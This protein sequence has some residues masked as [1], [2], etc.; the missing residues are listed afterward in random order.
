MRSTGN[1]IVSL[2][3]I[4]KTRTIQPGFYS[5][6]LSPTEKKIFDQPDIQQIPFHYFV[7][8]LWSIKESA[9]KYLQRINPDLVFS[10]IRF[11]VTHLEFSDAFS[12][13][14]FGETQLEADGFENSQVIKGSVTFGSTTLF[15][16]SV[17]YTELIHSVVSSSENFENI[18]WGIKLIERSD[19]AYQSSEVR[20]FLVDKLNKCLGVDGLFIEKDEWGVPMIVDGREKIEIALS[21]SHHDRFVGYSFDL[22][23]VDLAAI[24]G[25]VSN[26]P[27]CTPNK[28]NPF[29]FGTIATIR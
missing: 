28:P 13:T 18:G 26:N 1:D 22:S 21:L 23:I 15:S 4:N 12:L 24:V 14:N 3:A 20:V 10:P 5:K 19:P 7:W 16:R 27:L 17:M 6:F 9:Y 25:V 29:N 11:I 8:L 2:N